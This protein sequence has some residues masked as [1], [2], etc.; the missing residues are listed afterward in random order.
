MNTCQYCQKSFSSLQRLKGH[1][2]RQVCKKNKSTI[3]PDCS[4]SF[5]TLQMLQYHLDKKVCKKTTDKDKS[6]LF[7]KKE[8]SSIQR[9]NTHKAICP[10]HF[11]GDKEWHDRRCTEEYIW[12]K[13]MECYDCGDLI[14]RCGCKE[15]YMRRLVM[16]KKAIDDWFGEPFF[17]DLEGHP[18]ED[19]EY[20]EKDCPDC[21]GLRK[22]AHI[23]L[24]L[25]DK[26]PSYEYIKIPKKDEAYYSSLDKEWQSDNAEY[27]KDLEEWLKN[28]Y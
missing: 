7:C 24:C 26:E 2:E 15:E 6:C 5:S 17:D 8:F 12:P 27:F 10:D 13:D 21:R 3:C 9:L 23:S 4:K 11:C 16:E 19:I 25:Y 18:W 28:R 20:W 22:D 1:L 14:E